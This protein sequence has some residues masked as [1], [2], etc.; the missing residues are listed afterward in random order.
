MCW[1]GE[2]ITT[3][4]RDKQWNGRMAGH[5]GAALII[6]VLKKYIK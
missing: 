6:I 1:A 5:G 3:E 2:R 4:E